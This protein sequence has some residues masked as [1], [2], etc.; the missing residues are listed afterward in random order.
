MKL[1]VCIIKQQIYV[2]AVFFSFI[3]ASFICIT[4]VLNA[5]ASTPNAV[6]AFEAHSQTV[7]VSMAR[8][9]AITLIYI[10]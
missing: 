9:S 3:S 4:C 6:R 5:H 7:S 1:V 8:E 2:Y 10:K